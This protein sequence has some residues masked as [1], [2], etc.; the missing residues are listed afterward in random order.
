[1]GSPSASSVA[2]LLQNLIPYVLLI[3]EFVGVVRLGVWGVVLVVSV[4]VG[5]VVLCP[6]VR[7]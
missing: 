7:V 2:G 6:C 5:G 1:M 3:Q 4:C